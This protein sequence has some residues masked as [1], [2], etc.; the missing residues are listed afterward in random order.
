MRRQYVVRIVYLV[1]RIVCAKRE[2]KYDVA[3]GTLEIVNACLRFFSAFVVIVCL[4]SHALVNIRRENDRDLILQTVKGANLDYI[5]V[6]YK[7]LKRKRM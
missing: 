7:G 6:Q 3:D 4:K 1:N 5:R 2:I